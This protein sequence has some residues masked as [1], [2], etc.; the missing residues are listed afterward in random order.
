MRT[1]AVRGECMELGRSRRS[2]DAGNE[3]TSL[4]VFEV[5]DDGRIVYKGASTRTIRGRVSRTRPRYYAG[6]G[7]AFAEGGAGDN[8]TG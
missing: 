2:D 5:D 6:E 8:R 3:T 4:D 1:L 7:A